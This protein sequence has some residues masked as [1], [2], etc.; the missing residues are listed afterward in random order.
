[1]GRGDLAHHLRR[2][3]VGVVI[4]A[5]IAGIVSSI[6]TLG[7]LFRALHLAGQKT[8]TQ[9]TEGHQADA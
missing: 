6:V 5:L 2:L 3:D 8:A 4:G 7:I 1:M 9:G